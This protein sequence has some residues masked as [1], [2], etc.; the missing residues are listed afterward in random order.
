M[1]LTGRP[2]PTLCILALLAMGVTSGT[3]AQPLTRGA[4]PQLD[5]TT[6]I[7]LRVPIFGER[8]GPFA[9]GQELSIICSTEAADALSLSWWVS[10]KELI[11]GTQVKDGIASSSFT[12]GTLQMKDSGRR[13]TCRDLETQTENTIE[14]HVVAGLLAGT[15]LH[16]MR[17][18]SIR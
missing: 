2:S 16:I 10:D 7:K 5:I 17:S 4:S 12:L 1:A 11:N 3:I 6:S 9:T 18:S 14:L 15:L 8:I 13:F